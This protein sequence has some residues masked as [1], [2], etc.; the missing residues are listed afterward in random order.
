MQILRL[1]ERVEKRPPDEVRVL[2]EPIEYEAELYGVFLCTSV[3]QPNFESAWLKTLQ[4]FAIR[5]EPPVA[6]N[7]SCLLV[8]PVKITYLSP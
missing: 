7:I 1:T 4:D 6:S 8:L 3:A 2:K 5:R